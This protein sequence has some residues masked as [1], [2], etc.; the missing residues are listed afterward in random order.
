MTP[1]TYLVRWTARENGTWRSLDKTNTA[2]AG[3]LTVNHADADAVGDSIILPAG[4]NLHVPAG[5]TI[6]VQIRPF[7]GERKGAKSRSTINSTEYIA[8][9]YEPQLLA[10][11]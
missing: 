2:R 11:A 10:C 9:F 7:Y 5:Q 8:R 6:L 1:D 4:A 3:N